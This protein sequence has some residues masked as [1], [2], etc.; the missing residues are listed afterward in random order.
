MN[1]K[2]TAGTDA[3]LADLSSVFSDPG[4]APRMRQASPTAYDAAARF[5]RTVNSAPALT[6]RMKEL[7]LIALHATASTMD[8]P[9]VRRHVVRALEAGATQQDIV[10]VLVTIVGVANHALYFSVP[11]LVRELQAMDHPQAELPPLSAEGQA[12]KDEFV[13]ARG[14]WNE[15]RE[16]IARMM[17]EYFAALSEVTTES[18]SHGPLQEKDRELICI[19]VDSTP[20][21]MFE[22]GLAMHIRHALQK[23]ARREE[24]LEVLQLAAL[25][26]LEGYIQGAEALFEREAQEPR[27]R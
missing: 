13:R 6:P 25:T 14:F 11:V 8:G 19:A 24:I 1:T 4:V 23:G 20:T 9:G 15:P 17:P 16:V 18:W 3:H 7:V 12:I 5:W 22:P 2:T 10:D 21:H 27:A 26:G